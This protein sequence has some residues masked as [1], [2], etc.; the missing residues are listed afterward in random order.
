MI[1]TMKKTK[2]IARRNEASLAAMAGEIARAYDATQKL[3][4]EAQAKGVKAIKS[5]VE[6]GAVLNSAKETVGHG[7]WEGWLRKNCKRVSQMTATRYMR[8]AKSNTV[9]DLASCKSLRQAY[10]SSGI[11]PETPPQAQIQAPPEPPAA[12]KNEPGTAGQSAPEL[13]LRSS[14][15][16]MVV[17]PVPQDFTKS[18]GAQAS[19]QEV[20]AAP[21]R[22]KEPPAS[23]PVPDNRPVITL[24]PTDEAAV[25]RP[26]SAALAAWLRT[27]DGKSWLADNGWKE[28]VSFQDGGIDKADTDAVNAAFKAYTEAVDILDSWFAVPAGREWLKLPAPQEWLR[29]HTLQVPDS[30]VPV[31][32]PTSNSFREWVVKVSPATALGALGPGLFSQM[33]DGWLNTM[34]GQ[35]WRRDLENAAIAALPLPS[36]KALRAGGPEEDWHKLVEL[37]SKWVEDPDAAKQAVQPLTAPTVTAWA[38]TPEGRKWFADFS[39]QHAVPLPSA[40][41]R[42]AQERSDKEKKDVAD[43]RCVKVPTGP[44]MTLDLLKAGVET[45][46]ALLLPDAD[47]QKAGDILS[48]IAAEEMKRARKQPSGG[49][50]SAY[51][52]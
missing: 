47:H 48:T 42:R 25:F 10:L 32:N 23:P 33:M 5:A 18:T 46:V 7:G 21:L 15:T 30:A 17:R 11:L 27:P 45:L 34:S 31:P 12:P 8:L 40:E 49:R 37:S 2:S 44:P 39:A 1:V 36:G 20:S 14:P 50:F 41:Q 19:P 26:G 9:L 4:E 16:G 3:I 38:L 51:T 28:W 35:H 6:C 29:N 43:G 24:A 52:S 22:R 13:L